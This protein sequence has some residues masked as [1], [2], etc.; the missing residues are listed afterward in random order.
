[1]SGCHCT[2]FYL[3][4]ISPHFFHFIVERKCR[5]GARKL[6]GFVFLNHS[7]S[8]IQPLHPAVSLL[9]KPLSSSPAIWE[10]PHA[11]CPCLLH[12]KLHSVP[13]EN[14]RTKICNRRFFKQQWLDVVAV[15]GCFSSL[16]C[17]YGIIRLLCILIFPFVPLLGVGVI[18]AI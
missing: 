5:R 6:E 4:I 10:A 15:V 11:L 17:L 7:Q 2:L 8:I 1:M 9:P 14:V 3:P 13:K 18:T 16:N 12:L